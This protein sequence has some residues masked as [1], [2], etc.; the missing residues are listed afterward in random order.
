M[1]KITRRKALKLV[2]AGAAAIVAPSIA[3]AGTRLRIRRKTDFHSLDPAFLRGFEDEVLTASVLAPLLRYKGRASEAD[4]WGT[5]AHLASNL[6]VGQGGVE[7]DF[8]LRDEKWKDV[9][10][11]I[12]SEDVVF[13]F[14]RF[15]KTIPN[16]PLGQD[17][18]SSSALTSRSV[19]VSLRSPIMD[20]GTRFFATGYG[21]VLSKSALA[22]GTND[23]FGFIP[24]D[25]SGSFD[26]ADFQPHK[27]I[28]LRAN[29][30]VGWHQAHHR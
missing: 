12:G 9:A 20:F 21:A 16:H 8:E 1:R 29:F 7:Y 6:T 26:I 3:K 27:K 22:R 24:R 10:R 14:D 5:E 15:S 4:Q 17:I 13:S 11:P 18:A 25:H 2:T 28:V 30:V 23:D 19:R